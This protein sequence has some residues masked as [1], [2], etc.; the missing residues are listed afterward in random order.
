MFLALSVYFRHAGAS[1]AKGEH[2]SERF[3]RLVSK[4][5]LNRARIVGAAVRTAHML[6]IGMPG[7]IDMTPLS[8]D[9]D[10]LVLSIPPAFA[11]LEGERL[12]RRFGVLA[13]LLGKTPEIRKIR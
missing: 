6:S 7:V 5:S 11:G 3:K 13:T 4:R 9:G 10:R 12:Q 2:L 8:Y 1:E